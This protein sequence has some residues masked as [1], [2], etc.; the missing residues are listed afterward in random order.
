MVFPNEVMEVHHVANAMSLD[1]L[2]AMTLA[3]RAG[4]PGPIPGR[5]APSLHKFYKRQIF[6]TNI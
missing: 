5:G 4:D 1:G 2:M 3:C 6:S